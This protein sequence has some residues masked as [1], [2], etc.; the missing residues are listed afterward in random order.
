MKFII[1][2]FLLI[3]ISC[4]QEFVNSGT[5]VKGI[6]S[7]YNKIVYGTVMGEGSFFMA[8]CVIGGLGIDAQIKSA[9]IFALSKGFINSRAYVT[10]CS[11][12]YLAKQVSIQYRTKYHNGWTFK[13]GCNHWWVLNERGQEVFNAAGLHYTGCKK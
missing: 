11:G 13:K 4:D 3:S 7:Q 10:R 5:G 8:S 9:Y 12:D 2:L 1:A 6:S